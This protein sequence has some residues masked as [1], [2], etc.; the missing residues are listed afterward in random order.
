MTSPESSTAAVSFHKVDKVFGDAKQ[1]IRALDEVSFDVPDGSIY[2]VVGTSGAGKSTLIRTVNGLETASSGTVRVLGTEPA[3]L[4]PSGLRGL[5]RQ[6]SMVFQHYNLL[7]SKTVAENVAMPLMLSN[8]P[9]RE[10]RD[11]VHEVLTVVGLAD[12]ADHR[13]AQLSGGQRQ[14]VGIARALVTNP[15]LLLCDEPTSALDPLTTAQIL[16]LIVKINDEL[17]VT[18]LIITHQ[19]DV[20]AR[21]AEFVAVL[22]DGRVIEQ[23]RVEEIFAHPSA[24]L[25]RRFVQTVVPQR[26]PDAIEELVSS[27]RAGTVARVVHTQ[28][29]ARTLMTDLAERFKVRTS[30]LYATDAPLRHVTVGTLVMGMKGEGSAV[31]DAIG[32]I[33]HQEGLTVEVLHG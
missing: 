28:G 17:G 10:I 4:R 18:V 6:V 30:M 11:R 7:R 3:R 13:P 23:G 2:G 22:E 5:R 19:M 27:G 16:E 15:K 9:Q 32:W 31:T 24:D 1:P 21:I 33:G 26:L 14:R 8:T 29:A 12:R 25:T 20:I